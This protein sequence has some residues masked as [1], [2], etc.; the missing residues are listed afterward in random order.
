MNIKVI[1]LVTYLVLCTEMVFGVIYPSMEFL[2]GPCYFLTV[3]PV[4]Y[5]NRSGLL[6]ELWDIRMV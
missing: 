4:T 6:L 5:F 3:V 1:S 2:H